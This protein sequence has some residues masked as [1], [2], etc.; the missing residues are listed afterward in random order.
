MPRQQTTVTLKCV[1]AKGTNIWTSLEIDGGLSFDKVWNVAHAHSPGGV[2]AA[3]RPE[4]G[5][6]PLMVYAQRLRLL[7][8]VVRG[9]A[10]GNLSAIYCDSY[11]HLVPDS[12][13]R[14][15][16]QDWQPVVQ[17]DD[18]RP[19]EFPQSSSVIDGL[20]TAPAQSATV[21][22]PPDPLDVVYDDVDLR[23]LL[24]QADHITRDSDVR[25]RWFVQQGV[26]FTPAQKLAIA[27]YRSAQLRAKLKGER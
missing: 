10:A 7:E 11:E 17:W 25:F 23:C 16:L 5:D 22:V 1:D 2:P 19:A 4:N 24:Y 6:L 27:E 15:Y 26:K 12:A 13:P 20:E 8:Q 18:P 14:P 3:L 21:A 9:F